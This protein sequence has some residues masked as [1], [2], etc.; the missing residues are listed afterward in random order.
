MKENQEIKVKNCILFQFIV[1]LF[2]DINLIKNVQ[3]TNTS[4]RAIISESYANF[5]VVEPFL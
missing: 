2:V 4:L 3:P 5:G 1:N